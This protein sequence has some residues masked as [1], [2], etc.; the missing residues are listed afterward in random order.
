MSETRIVIFF[1]EEGFYPLELPVTDDLAEHARWNPGTL[2]IEDTEGN[3][4]SG[5]PPMAEL[6]AEQRALDEFIDDFVRWKALR[7]VDVEKLR[8]AG[9]AI[10][11]LEPGDIDRIDEAIERRDPTWARRN[12]RYD[13]HKIIRAAYSTIAGGAG[14]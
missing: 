9:F 2:R 10:I 8:A 7:S 5:R 4:L 14:E 6:T 11:P 3:I 12:G 1:R 13:R